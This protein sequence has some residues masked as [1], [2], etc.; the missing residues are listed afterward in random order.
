MNNDVIEFY[1]DLDNNVL[2]MYNQRTDKSERWEEM[3]NYDDG[4]R[5]MFEMC[6]VGEV[7]SLDV[8]DV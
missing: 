8:V 7:V 4:V 2:T 6:H 1:L 5:P 3:I